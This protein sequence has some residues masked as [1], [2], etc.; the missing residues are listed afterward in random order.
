[1]TGPMYIISEARM[2]RR[3]KKTGN[4]GGKEKE[5][6][7]KQHEVGRFRILKIIQG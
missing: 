5:D 7:Y 4:K 3:E 1:M 6:G 2:K